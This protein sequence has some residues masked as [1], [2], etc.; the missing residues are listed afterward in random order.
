MGHPF[1]ETMTGDEAYMVSGAY[2][3]LVL[4]MNTPVR[5]L[6][7][8]RWDGLLPFAD[9]WLNIKEC[10]EMARK[11]GL[12]GTKTAGAV[13]GNGD[14]KLTWVNVK[15][16]EEME[17][18]TALLS[19]DAEVIAAEYLGLV[20]EGLDITLKRADPET[21]MACAYG[22][23]EDGQRYGVSAWAGTPL[24]ACAALVV[25]MNWLREHIEEL[26]AAPT[27]KRRFR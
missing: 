6:R 4:V 18:E 24:D 3:A 14:V 8:N 26:A 12:V 9:Y 10:A 17:N 25:K 5:R 19:E 20:G 23:Q 22:T 1:W 11:R 2:H 7:V 15:L 21:F 16:T 13:N 27:I